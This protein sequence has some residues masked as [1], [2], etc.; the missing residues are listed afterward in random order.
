MTTNGTTMTM[1]MIERRT[2]TKLATMTST[3]T[4]QWVSTVAVLFVFAEPRQSR[5]AA[6][7]QQQQI[8][9]LGA[10]F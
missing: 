6:R 4:L 3:R 7:E 5:V 1:T 9:S 8:D 2:T 10:A